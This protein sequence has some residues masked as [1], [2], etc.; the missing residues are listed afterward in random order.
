M[1]ISLNPNLA[2]TLDLSWI[3]L[4]GESSDYAVKY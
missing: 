3:T 1:R 4:G 2:G